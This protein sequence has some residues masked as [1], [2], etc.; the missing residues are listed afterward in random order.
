MTPVDF[1]TTVAVASTKVVAEVCK[2]SLA[3]FEYAQLKPCLGVPVDARP[4]DVDVE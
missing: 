4:P 1:V 2:Q 3:L